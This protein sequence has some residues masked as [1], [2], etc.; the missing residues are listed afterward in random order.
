MVTMAVST[1][2][3]LVFL[4]YERGLLY[5]TPCPHTLERHYGTPCLL[6]ASSPFLKGV[7]LHDYYLTFFVESYGTE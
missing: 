3:I 6:L 2:T 1:V 5:L 4:D 7:K